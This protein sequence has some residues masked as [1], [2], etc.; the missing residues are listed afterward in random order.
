MQMLVRRYYHQDPRTRDAQYALTE[1][2]DECRHSVMFGRLI[3]RLGTPVYPSN[4]VDDVLGKLI[5][6]M[7]RGAE[8][9]AMILI[10]EEILDRFQREIMADESLQPLIRMVSRVHVV[11]EARHV[12]YARA[13]L[14]R[15]MASAGHAQIALAR[16]TVGRAACSVAS[17]LVHPSVYAAVGIDPRVGRAAARRNPHWQATM[18]W[19]AEK[20]TRS[21]QELGLIKGPGAI[22]WRRS[23][24]L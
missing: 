16:V 19:S 13:A 14:D 23:G 3:D 8:M 4:R 7:A 15:K 10:A 1:V 6:S 12:R 21:F 24:L 20:V 17:R 9:Y 5:K 22:L 11:E 2:A 18:R